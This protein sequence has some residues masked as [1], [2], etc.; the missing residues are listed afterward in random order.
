MKVKD[1]TH[2]IIKASAD[3]TVSDAARTMDSKNIGCLPL[4]KDNKIVGIVTERDILKKI[5]AR[6]RNPEKTLVREIMSSPVISISPEKDIDEANDLMAQKRVRRLLVESEEGLIGIITVRDV[7]DN[8]RYSLGK[9]I[10]DKRGIGR[11][12][13]SP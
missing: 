5:V 10:I 9:S 12:T 7:S 3:S 13:E 6:G 4:E 2:P 1:I 8:L 11:N